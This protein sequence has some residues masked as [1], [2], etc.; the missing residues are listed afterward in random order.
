M[1]VVLVEGAGDKQA[2]P[3]LLQR[4]GID[5]R[6]RAVDM[7]GKSNIIRKEHGFEDTVRRQYALGGRSFVI[8]MDGDVTFPPYESL[9]EERDDMPHRA[10]A[11]EEEL[12]TPVRVF[13]AVREME[14]WLIG[15]LRPGDRYC[16]LKRIKQVPTNTEHSPPDPKRWLE[17]HL[18]TGGYTPRTQRCLAKRIDIEQARVRNRSMRIFLEAVSR[19]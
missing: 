14:S 2:L 16:G 15:G 4:A 19:S 10:E 6:I 17:R 12:G 13:W 18:R 3:I 11:L 5:V 1:I 9:E 8:L 7:K